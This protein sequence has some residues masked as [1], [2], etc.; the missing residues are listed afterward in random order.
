MATLAQAHS[1]SFPILV[2]GLTHEAP[3]ETLKQLICLVTSVCFL[4]APLSLMHTHTVQMQMEPESCS[5][6]RIKRKWDAAE[7]NSLI[8][9]GL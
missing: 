7:G 9:A 3:T 8:L 1:Y 5:Q 6:V 2:I 4:S